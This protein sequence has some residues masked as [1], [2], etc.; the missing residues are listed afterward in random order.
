MYIQEAANTSPIL[1]SAIREK[2]TDS[3]S[4]LYITRSII[5]LEHALVYNH[6]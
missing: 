6:N 5:V 2:K 4:L 3:G 1:P